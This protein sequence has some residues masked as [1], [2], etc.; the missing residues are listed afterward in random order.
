MGFPLSAIL[1]FSA[2]LA[3]CFAITFSAAATTDPIDPFFSLADSPFACFF[4]GPVGFAATGRPGAP[5][6]SGSGELEL[7]ATGS[8][9]SSPR[10]RARITSGAGGSLPRA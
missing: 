6:T 3:S 5:H 9:M 2:A 10:A 7:I 8:G 1:S 4:A